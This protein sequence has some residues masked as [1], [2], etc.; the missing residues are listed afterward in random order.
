MENMEMKLHFFIEAQLRAEN[1]KKSA[2][3]SP[4]RGKKTNNEAKANPNAKCDLPTQEQV[5][6]VELFSSRSKKKI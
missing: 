4:R 3:N 2:E 6:L 5:L 1:V